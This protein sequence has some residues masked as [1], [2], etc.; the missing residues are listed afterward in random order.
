MR[1]QMRSRKV[2]RLDRE[3]HYMG[4]ANV[5]AGKEAVEAFEHKPYQAA[6]MIKEQGEQIE[7]E[8]K[9]DDICRNGLENLSH[10]NSA[11]TGKNH[12]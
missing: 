4:L 2:Q 8:R 9:G 7:K 11:R 10:T 6:N 12:G 3:R 1:K 5:P